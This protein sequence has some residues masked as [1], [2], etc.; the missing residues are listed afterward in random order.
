MKGLISIDG[1]IEDIN[2][3]TIPI[4]D[5]TFLYG[6][7]VLEVLLAV[8]QN[9]LNLNK[10]L[11]RLIYSAK[12][13]GITIPW[14]KSFFYR[15][16]CKLLEALNAKETYLRLVISRGSGFGINTAAKLRPRCIIFAF[17]NTSSQQ[18]STSLY[19][20]PNHSAKRGL[21]PK[22]TNYQKTQAALVA[23]HTSGYNDILWFN[24][25]GEIT[26]T[27]SANIFF[28]KKN[29]ASYEVHTPSCQSGLLKGLTR[30]IILESLLRNKIKLRIRT[31]YKDEIPDFQEA[32]SCSTIRGV[33]RVSQI[34]GTFYK[35]RY[36]YDLVR[37]Y[38]LEWKKDQM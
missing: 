8:G 10:H 1:I 7:G 27:S 3:A 26:E 34:N 18:N 5:R 28:I 6:D 32:F 19:L 33:F 11:T 38:Y 23:A 29:Q 17:E 21:L 14:S 31:I 25:A 9:T 22:T 16:I 12:T 2:S 37:S 30:N 15:E 13:Q 20:T 24:F 4:S 36:Y 35:Q